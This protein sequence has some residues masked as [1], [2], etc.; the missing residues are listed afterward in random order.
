MIFPTWKDRL[1]L[2]WR[3][4][5]SQV[6][7][8]HQSAE[9]MADL[10]IGSWRIED[11]TPCC[12]SSR[13]NISKDMERPSSC[14]L[15][16]VKMSKCLHHRCFFAWV[17]AVSK[18]LWI[19]LGLPSASNTLPF[20]WCIQCH[21]CILMPQWMCWTLLQPNGHKTQYSSCIGSS[22][23]SCKIS[24]ANPSASFHL[25]FLLC[26]CGFAIVHSSC[27]VRIVGALLLH[28]MKTSS[29]DLGILSLNIVISSQKP[30]WSF[31]ALLPKVRS[32]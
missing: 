29:K 26:P 5:A 19:F 21:W 24:F 8:L 32:V 4:V 3:E 28:L 9:F 7:Q 13:A 12:S 23:S 27:R 1:N 17:V 31:D 6:D 22:H 10:G 11:H 25:I 16:V 15:Q 2:G 14:A 30:A 18:R 20:T